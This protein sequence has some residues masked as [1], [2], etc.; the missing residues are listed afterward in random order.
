MQQAILDI[1]YKIVNDGYYM[2]I[3]GVEPKRVYMSQATFN[4]MLRNPDAVND[5]VSPTK[6]PK[7][8]RWFEPDR[9]M[10]KKPK[11]KRLLGLNIIIDDN[12]LLG[13]VVVD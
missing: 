3:Q 1:L 11:A 12:L 8:K 2:R 4:M 9:I 6:K 13:D 7:T 5:E 10:R